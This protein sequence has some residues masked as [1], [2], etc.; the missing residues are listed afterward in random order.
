M[1]IKKCYILVCT[2][3]TLIAIVCVS[4]SFVVGGGS[5]D[6]D[7]DFSFGGSAIA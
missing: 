7:T 2:Q 6:V 1:S 4:E 5:V 3:F